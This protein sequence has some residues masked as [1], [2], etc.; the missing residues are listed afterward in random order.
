MSGGR[1][2]HSAHAVVERGLL[3]VA[4]TMTMRLQR[5]MARR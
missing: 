1:A 5:A 4:M 2:L 3:A